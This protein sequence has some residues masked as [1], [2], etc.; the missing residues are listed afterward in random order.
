MKPEIKH[1]ITPGW[2]DL[3]KDNEDSDNCLTCEKLLLKTVGTS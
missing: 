3:S 1:K 2:G